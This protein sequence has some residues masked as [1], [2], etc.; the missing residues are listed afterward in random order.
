MI[1]CI[2][3]RSAFMAYSQAEEPYFVE[4]IRYWVPFMS[5]P[6]APATFLK[7]NSIL[8][9]G[10]SARLK[11]HEMLHEIWGSVEMYSGQVDGSRGAIIF[12]FPDEFS[13]RARALLEILGPADI[14]SDSSKILVYLCPLAD[15]LQ[16]YASRL[17]LAYIRAVRPKSELEKLPILVG[18]KSFILEQYL[19]AGRDG[20]VYRAKETSGKGQFIVK[21]FMRQESRYSNEKNAHH[22]ISNISPRRKPL[23][24]DDT[25]EV[26]AYP[27]ISG[28]TLSAKLKTVMASDE[29]E[30]W[31][32]KLLDLSEYFARSKTITSP[33]Y[34]NI[35]SVD[36]RI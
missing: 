33:F 29:I 17:S 28:L 15:S 26:L 20:I 22:M 4:L 14:R 31:R 18:G 3:E 19:A 25:D 23:A 21:V 9:I 7:T 34:V 1:C 36:Y 12:A 6:V 27:Y 35:H 5:R 13:G 2:I 32:N 24:F 16:Q 8:Q 10:T 11:V 30:I